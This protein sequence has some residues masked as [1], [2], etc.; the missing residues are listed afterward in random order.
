MSDVLPTRP[1]RTGVTT[2]VGVAAVVRLSR[3]LAHLS[4]RTLQRL[5]TGLSTGARPAGRDETSALR[6][7]VLSASAYC[8]G[9]S[10]CLPRSLAVVLL[11]R[12][13]GR[14]PDWCVGVLATPPFTAHAWLEVDGEVVDEPLRRDDVRTF[15]RVRAT[16]AAHPETDRPTGRPRPVVGS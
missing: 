14:W 2:T 3:G 5:L 6:D 1:R 11:S 7:T 8:R 15:F 9:D 12:L 13:R 16:D 4:P 10:A